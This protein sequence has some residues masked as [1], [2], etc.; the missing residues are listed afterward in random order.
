MPTP[1]DGPDLNEA[2]LGTSIGLQLAA[3]VTALRLGW[4][5]A[6][7]W[8]WRF[9]A[10]ALCAMLA[11]LLFT[12]W[13]VL[14]TSEP[15]ALDV[16]A[17]FVAIS[18][19][20]LMLTGLLLLF[21]LFSGLQSAE[22]RL[23]AIVDTAVDAIL[24]IDE[25]GAVETLNPAAQRLF[26]YESS[27]VVG[28]NI[29]MLMPPPYSDEHD[30]YLARYLRTGEKRIIGAGRDVTGLRADGSTFPLH[31]T[32]S[33]MTVRGR[34]MFT[35]IARDITP[36]KA[37][38]R[39]LQERAEELARSNSELE[40]FAYV[41]SHDLQEPL[42]MIASFTQLLARS[43]AGRRDA[44]AEE[45]MGYVIE[46]VSR[47][48][49]LIDG[50]LRLSRVGRGS[51]FAPVDCNVIL[52]ECLPGLRVAME[53]SGATV[54]W[55]ELPK[56][57]ADALQIANLFQN[58]IGNAIKFQSAARTPHVHVSVKREAPAWVF[59]VRDNGI[60]IEQQYAARVFVIFQRLHGRDE[61][62]GTGIGLALCKK[63]VERHG[64]T[65]W[66]ESEPGQ[67]TTF[68]FRIPDDPEAR[69]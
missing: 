35:E 55:E 59:R 15:H 30:E 32:V 16:G 12:A 42:R 36:M 69:R 31:L 37:A 62:P 22:A 13:H 41:A 6:R 34:R 25:R 29:E 58:L 26:G 21:P 18:V 51:D 68:L 54:T 52:E 56:I 45:F 28:R 46:G 38:E 5:S 65:I 23:S 40:Q 27:Q 49:A 14:S 43:D 2:I 64:G 24:T 50:L 63:I 11:R 10:L 67:G 61:Y 47:M 3:L 9:V 66:F 57:R 60:G 19:S 8:G 33:E 7:H 17:E 53:E 4:L 39:A 1:G 44:E 20:A 48:Q